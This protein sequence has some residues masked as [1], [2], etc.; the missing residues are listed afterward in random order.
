MASSAESRISIIVDQVMVEERAASFTNRSI[1]CTAKLPGL[2][3]A[4]AMMDLTTLEGKDTPGKV[5]FLCGK[6]MTPIDPKYEVPTCG[7]V[8]VYPSMVRYARKFLGQNS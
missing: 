2:K 6:A 4:V 8:C 5:A 3:M 1:K 7:A